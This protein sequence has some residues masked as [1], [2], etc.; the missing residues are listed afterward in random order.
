[1]K[2]VSLTFDDGRKDNLCFAN[3]IL[4]DY[5]MGAT[6][7]C[8]TGFV[9]GS[10]EKPKDWKSAGVPLSIEDLLTLEANG[11]EIALHGDQHI[12]SIDDCLKSIKKIESM[13]IK[14]EKYGFSVPNSEIP[15]NTFSM[16]VE[17]LRSTELKYIRCGRAIDTSSINSKILFAG[18]T[19]VGLQKAYNMFNKPSVIDIGQFDA[20][21]LP[22]VVIRCEDKPDMVLNFLERLPNNSWVIFM[23]HSILPQNALLYGTDPWNW[24]T[25][26]FDCLVNGL[27]KM[28]DVIVDTVEGVMNSISQR[29]GGLL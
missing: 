14:K 26:N 4:N 24:S 10:F 8:T 29:D 3:S 23:L 11:W 1:M 22:S 5:K 19:F 2:Y 13:G 27:S 9:D 16:F 17:K 12:T 15:E 18:Y 7:F 25:D 28:N 21:N 6:L 20:Y